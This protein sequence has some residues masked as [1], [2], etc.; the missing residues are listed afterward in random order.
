MF[1]IF[2]LILILLA[3]LLS[4]QINAQT[5]ENHF[6][7]ND[8]G[9]DL[10][11]EHLIAMED[12]SAV[13]T[14]E[15]NTLD[16]GSYHVL[17]VR[18]DSLGNTIWLRTYHQG[19]GKW[20]CK[21]LDGGFIV[22]GSSSRHLFGSQQGFI[23]KVN[24]SGVE[25]WL[26]YLPGG[27]HSY[28]SNVVQLSSGEIAVCGVEVNEGQDAS[29]KVFWALFSASGGMAAYQVIDQMERSYSPKIA[30]DKN[31]NLILAWSSLG[32]DW[33]RCFTPNGQTVWEHNLTEGF[34][35]KFKQSSLL[36]DSL[37]DVWVAGGYKVTFNGG[38]PQVLQFSSTGSLKYKIGHSDR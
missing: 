2:R 15:T 4:G 21:T 13:I 32:P 1:P 30:E 38:L 27:D 3:L 29:Q 6:F 23:L 10:L 33:L 35:Y 20:V 36:V 11:P 5:L 17:L 25:E 9:A 14:G 12:G 26:Q 22:G 7:G 8:V 34:D 18:T 28:V 16:T 31:S 24:E 37:G 19:V